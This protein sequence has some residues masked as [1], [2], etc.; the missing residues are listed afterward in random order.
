MVQYSTKTPVERLGRLRK[1]L[2]GRVNDMAL[3]E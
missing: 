1:Q 2:F 3:G